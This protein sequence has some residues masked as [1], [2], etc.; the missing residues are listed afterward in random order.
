MVFSLFKK[1][2]QKVPQGEIMRPKPAFAPTA[3]QS[4]LPGAPEEAAKP[5]ESLP[6]LE[7]TPG[8]QSVSCLLYT[9]PS[10]RD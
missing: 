6:D 1:K 8:G 9:S 7:F 4:V 2:G 5:P 10:P 3:G